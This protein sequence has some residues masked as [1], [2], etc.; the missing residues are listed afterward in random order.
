M[1]FAETCLQLGISLTPPQFYACAY[2]ENNGLRFCVDFGYQNAIDKAR[3]HW[4]KRRKA[5]R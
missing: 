5:R 1:K 4:R 3:E 2:L